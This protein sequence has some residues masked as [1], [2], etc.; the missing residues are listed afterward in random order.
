MKPVYI[1]AE[2]GVN[3]NGNLDL[4]MSLIDAAKDAGV[5]AVKFQTFR[6][7]SLVSK[8]AKKAKYQEQNTGFAESQLE[9]LRKL[10]LS[11]RDHFALMERCKDKK[12]EF[13][14]TAFDFDSIDFLRSLNLRVWKIPSGEI[15]NLLYLRKIGSF[16]ERVII[17]TG[18][19]TM[20][21]VEAA[22]SALEYSGTPRDRISVLHC[23]TEYPAPLEEVN[24]RSMVTL[25]NAFGV[26]FGYSDHTQGITVP[27]AAVA[28]GASIIEKH[29]TL[30]KR[31]DGPDHKA[32]LEP[33]ELRSMVE[34]I[35]SVEIAMG[36]GIKRPFASELANRT[37]ARKSIVAA[38]SIEKGEPFSTENLTVKRPG[39]GI[40]PMEW[41]RVM[42]RIADRSYSE[43]E[44]IVW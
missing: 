27:I 21:E 3:H 18:M 26:E 13:L 38:R 33:G 17:S 23:T 15:T 42:G 12:I 5:D 11:Q 43:D 16:G 36:D 9:M 31:M 28:L 22:I 2:A 7:E 1:I 24:L 37:V 44:A 40:S 34:A 20:G 4:A 10:E 41:D 25:G 30:D 32:S 19:A 29:F 35:R 39:T 8:G 14:S 6:S